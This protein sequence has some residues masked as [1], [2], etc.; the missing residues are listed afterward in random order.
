LEDDSSKHS[1]SNKS[2][3]QL[4]RRTTQPKDIANMIRKHH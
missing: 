4:S 2:P 3:F 1:K